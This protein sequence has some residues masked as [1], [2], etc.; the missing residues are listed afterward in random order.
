[1]NVYWT[2]TAIQHLSS[3][4]TYL[5]QTSPAYAQRTIDDQRSVVDHRITRCSQ[6]I[7]TFPNSGRVVP[8]FY[9]DRIREI[10]EGKYR[11]IYTLQ[12]N[13]IEVLAV[14]HGAQSI[15]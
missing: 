11:I 13:Q 2:E 6:Q 9:N 1:M 3:L 8:E 15:E 10:I 12:S 14:L 4:Y 5:S 7:A